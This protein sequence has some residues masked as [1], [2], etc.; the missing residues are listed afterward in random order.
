MHWDQILD[1]KQDIIIIALKRVGVLLFRDDAKVPTEMK[2]ES[3]C[4][5]PMQSASIKH[6][7]VARSLNRIAE[8]N[9]ELPQADLSR[10]PSALVQVNVYSMQFKYLPPQFSDVICT[11]R[12]PLRGIWTE[13]EID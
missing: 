6:D 10:K 11:D 7:A 4:P 8:G 2:G 3:K 12:E 9:A 5:D 13:I 1:P